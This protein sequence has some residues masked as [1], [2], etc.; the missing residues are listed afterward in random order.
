MEGSIMVNVQTAVTAAVAQ[1][2][3][4]AVAFGLVNSTEA[5]IAITASG[6][7]INTAI[8]VA[9]AIIKHGQSKVKAAEIAAGYKVLK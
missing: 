5:S 6:T 4:L 3:T 7:L 8:V 9:D 1:I 2:I